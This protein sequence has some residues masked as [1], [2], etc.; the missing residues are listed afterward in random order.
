LKG[1]CFSLKE[2]SLA[3]L[4][5]AMGL[6]LSLLSCQTPLDVMRRHQR[7]DFPTVVI[8]SEKK[9]LAEESKGMLGIWLLPKSMPHS[10]PGSTALQGLLPKAISLL[11]PG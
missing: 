1:K 2:K 10:T 8:S 3:W 5:L 11:M 6:R 9:E 4:H 7:Y